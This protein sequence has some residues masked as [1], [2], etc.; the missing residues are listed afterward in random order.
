VFT[1]DILLTSSG[2]DKRE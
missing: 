2:V 1:F